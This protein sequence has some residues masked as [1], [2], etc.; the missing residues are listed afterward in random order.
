MADAPLPEEAKPEAKP[1]NW[2]GYTKEYI[3]IVVGVLTA[4][5]AQ[6]AADWLRWRGEVTTAKE[7][8]AAEMAGNVHNAIVRLRTKDCTER[9]LD[10]LGVILDAAAASGKLPPV[11]D[12][13]APPR[14]VWSN[15]AW[16]S[17]VASQAATHF[18]RQQLSSLGRLYGYVTIANN[19]TFEEVAAW[20][21]LSTM[22]GP[23]RRL[24]PASE[25]ALRNSLSQARGQNRVF[26]V[27]ALAV[28][29]IQKEQGLP[30]NQRDLKLISAARDESLA[31][32][33]VTIEYAYPQ[34]LSCRP[35]GAAP[36]QYGQTNIVDLPGIAEA[37]MKL[38][39]AT[40]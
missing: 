34:Y 6:Q 11:G 32:G 39:P 5:A 10:E 25:A 9:R 26:A 22:V 31:E 2:R 30:Y 27:I 12:I 13:G 33:Q 3:V 16:E 23:G 15:G 37:G 1:R 8:I 36:S 40:P 17:V 20:S 21:N 28:L 24:D 38:L 35:I 14:R 29:Q 7:A 19:L 18:P 4:L